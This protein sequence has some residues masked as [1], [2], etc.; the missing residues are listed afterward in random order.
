MVV[1]A[2]GVRLIRVIEHYKPPASAGRLRALRDESEFGL[3]SPDWTEVIG[4]LFLE[5]CHDVRANCLTTSVLR[6]SPAS[7]SGRGRSKAANT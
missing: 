1:V 5:R 6:L 4:D 7:V 2:Q 3:R